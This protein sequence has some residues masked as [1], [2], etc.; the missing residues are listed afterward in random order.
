M[1][2]TFPLS[3]G[4]YL[5]APPPPTREGENI[6]D[7]LWWENMKRTKRKMGEILQEKEESVKKKEKMGSKRLK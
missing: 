6:S 7:A 4:V 2:F 5:D 3:P 1:F